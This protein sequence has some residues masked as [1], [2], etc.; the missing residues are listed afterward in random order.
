MNGIGVGMAVVRVN[1]LRMKPE[2]VGK[3]KEG[4]GRKECGEERRGERGKGRG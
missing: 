4:M 3:G 2:C 1:A